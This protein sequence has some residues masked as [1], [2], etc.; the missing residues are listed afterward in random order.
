MQP[1]D[2]AMREA[3]LHEL[4]DDLEALADDLCHVSEATRFN[5]HTQAAGI[6]NALVALIDK[7]AHVNETPKSEHVPGDVLTLTAE[8][9]RLAAAVDAVMADRARIIEERDRGFVMVMERAERAEA[10]VARLT[11]LLP[12]PGETAAEVMWRNHQRGVRLEELAKAAGVTRERARQMVRKAEM[13][14]GGA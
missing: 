4:A 3:A 14:M 5:M 6:R 7:P 8:R 2:A 9:D 1:D 11:A 13:R 10:E 12:H